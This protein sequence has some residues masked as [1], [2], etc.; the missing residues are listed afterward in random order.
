LIIENSARPGRV[1]ELGAPNA[2]CQAA[3]VATLLLELN[4]AAASKR[5]PGSVSLR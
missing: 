5:H 3:A 1:D 2:N 4:I